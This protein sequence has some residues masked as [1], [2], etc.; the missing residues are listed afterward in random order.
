MKA[1]ACRAIESSAWTWD[2]PAPAVF[3]LGWVGALPLAFALVSTTRWWT[4]RQLDAEMFLLFSLVLPWPE[5][6]SATLVVATV[7]SMFAVVLAY[8]GTSVYKLVAGVVIVGAL[9]IG[10]MATASAGAAQA[11]RCVDGVARST[12]SM[13]TGFSLDCVK[14]GYH[15]GET[16]E[17][18]PH[19]PLLAIEETYEAIWT[20]EPRTGIARRVSTDV[21]VSRDTVTAPR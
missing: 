19:G 6:L 20:F 9:F 5:I 13:I 14:L 11:L 16:G 18:L 7:F 1:R 15:R 3:M 4:L 10:L 21:F 2:K 8:K 17:G 12:T